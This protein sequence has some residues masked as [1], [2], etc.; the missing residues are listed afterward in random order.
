VFDFGVW[1]L[2][3]ILCESTSRGSLGYC[4]ILILFIKCLEVYWIGFVQISQTK[5]ECPV[6]AVLIP[7]RVLLNFIIAYSP[8]SR[9]HQGT[10]TSTIILF[11]NQFLE[12][13]CLKPNHQNKSEGVWIGRAYNFNPQRNIKNSWSQG[14]VILCGLYQYHLFKVAQVPFKIR[15]PSLSINYLSCQNW[16]I[17]FGKHDCLVLD[18]G[19][20]RP[21]SL[22]SSKVLWT[23]PVI[24]L[25]VILVFSKIYFW[26]ISSIYLD[27]CDHMKIL[28]CINRK[29]IIDEEGL[30][31]S[32][33]LCD[34]E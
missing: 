1:I 31:W 13:L 8:P 6:L 14:D 20:V 27:L 5:P 28:W 3:Y 32:I 26:F 17:R 11:L 2:E 33:S 4:Y 29:W 12:Y 24:P 19:H 23:C 9:R 15:I 22:G 10:F 25:D 18:T 34:L 16:S 30:S 21:F 7:L